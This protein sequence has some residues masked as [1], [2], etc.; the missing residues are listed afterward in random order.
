MRS[1]VALQAKEIMYT[2]FGRKP[3]T[4]RNFT[5]NSTDAF[6]GCKGSKMELP[7]GSTSGANDKRLFHTKD[8]VSITPAVLLTFLPK[9]KS[10]R[11]RRRKL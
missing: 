3:C 10:R 2:N 11:H 8:S 6:S 9:T 4:Q 5:R 7:F 1:T